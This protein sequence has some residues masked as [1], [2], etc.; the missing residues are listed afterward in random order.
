MEGRI[1]EESNAVTNSEQR[2]RESNTDSS[3]VHGHV[4]C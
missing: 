1:S 2:P 4:M 3:D